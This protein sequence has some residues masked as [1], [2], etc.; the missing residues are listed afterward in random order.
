MKS[1]TLIFAFFAAT[2]M[3]LPSKYVGHKYTSVGGYSGGLES[4]VAAASIGHEGGYE[5][6]GHG[7]DEGHYD[8]HVDY[9]HYPKYEVDY[10]VHDPHTGDYKKVWETRDGDVV[11]GGYTFTEA[12]GSVRV[13]EYTSDHKNGFNAVVKNLGGHGHGHH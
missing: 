5:G 8:H 11:K 10:G 12:D 2:A 13:V 4:Y 1:F 3:A 7:G 6:H 9:F